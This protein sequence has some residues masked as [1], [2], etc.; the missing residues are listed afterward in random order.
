MKKGFTQVV[1]LAIIKKDNKYLFTLRN[2]ESSELHNKW[3][4]AGG[5]LEFAEKP[6]ETLHREVMEELGTEVQ[7]LHPEPFVETEIRG[8]W[9]G[10]FI[11]Y[12]CELKDPHAEI[13][14]NEEASDYKWFTL[15]ELS[16][17]DLLPGCLELVEKAEALNYINYRDRKLSS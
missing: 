1:V 14:L 5:G 17:L 3:Q 11:A 16:S 13:R 9:Q 8:K 15:E 12:L 4:I 2:E 6:L 10:I 7:L